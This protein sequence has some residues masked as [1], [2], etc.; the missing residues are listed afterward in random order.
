[1]A[2]TDRTL[3]E[4]LT[5]LS[6]PEVLDAAKRFFARR[7]SIYTAFL[8]MEGPTFVSLRGMGGEEVVIGVSQRL[9]ATAV[10]GSTYMFDQQVARFLA[11]LPTTDA[12]GVDAIPLELPASSEVSA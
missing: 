5:S 1:M 6:P 11:S 4:T 2:Q 12:L 7:N 10:T 3:Q 8:D 9:G